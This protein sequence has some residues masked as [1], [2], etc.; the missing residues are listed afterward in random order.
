MA[1]S[2]I[3]HWY[4]H[5]VQGSAC[6]GGPPSAD[7]RLPVTWVNYYRTRVVVAGSA[8]SCTRTVAMLLSS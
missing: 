2:R 8:E 6:H 3:G 5:L 7:V 4:L 1:L